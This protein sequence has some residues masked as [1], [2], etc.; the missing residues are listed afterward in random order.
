MDS[1][2]ILELFQLPNYSLTSSENNTTQM[3][4]VNLANDDT[5]WDDYCSEALKGLSE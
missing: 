4:E 1:I 5:P 2:Y 3:T